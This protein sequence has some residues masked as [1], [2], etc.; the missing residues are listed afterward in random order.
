[1]FVRTPSNLP[2]YASKDRSE[3]VQWTRLKDRSEGA[4]DTPQKTAVK[5]EFHSLA[6]VW[7]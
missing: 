6:H 4:V 5:V 2:V 7:Q 1:M 3:G